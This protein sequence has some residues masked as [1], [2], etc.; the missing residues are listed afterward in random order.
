M[1]P[2][3]AGSIRELAELPQQRANPCPFATHA[4]CYR[5]KETRASG[6]TRQAMIL[7]G[8]RRRRGVDGVADQVRAFDF[9][10]ASNGRRERLIV[11]ARDQPNP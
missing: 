9:V 3:D 4:G 6:S 11:L 1:R 8:S 7:S 10:I 2:F 5:P